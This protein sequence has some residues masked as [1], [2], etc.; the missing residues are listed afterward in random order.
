MILK[1][2]SKREV[3]DEIKNIYLSLEEIDIIKNIITKFPI[4]YSSSKIIKN[5]ADYFTHV[6]TL[7]IMRFKLKVPTLLM[8]EI[9]KTSHRSI[10]YR[11]KIFGW[12][13]TLHESQQIA[14]EKSRDYLQIRIKGKKTMLESLNK[15][16][17]EDKIR[18]YIN[19]RL[20]ELLPMAELIVGTNNVSI[21]SNIN[22][23][24]DIP[25]IIF[26]NNNIYKY[27]LE[28]NGHYWHE[29]IERNNE[30]LKL[31]LLKQKGYQHLE[32][33]Q[34][35]SNEQREE[36]GLEGVKKDLE[37]IINQIVSMVH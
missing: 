19:L 31:S 12:N 17:L 1:Q 23:E 13:Y 20:S 32:I 25:I 14:A 36:K 4:K 7:Y 5:D 3:I 30:D 6:S 27:A 37:N 16:N 15:S 34:C 2:I 18:E 28:I 11:L 10:Q 26:F 29:V 24:I 33:W 9:T 35:I 21:L 22:K 8:S